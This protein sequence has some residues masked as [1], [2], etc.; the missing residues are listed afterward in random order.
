MGLVGLRVFILCVLVL[1]VFCIGCSA[2]TTCDLEDVLLRKVKRRKRELMSLYSE[3]GE[4]RSLAACPSKF[5]IQ[6][7]VPQ[8]A[9][10]Q[11]THTL[12]T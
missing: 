1:F 4:K 10:S 5:I 2:C 6:F 9:Q 12:H 7:F 8:N 11:L 3:T